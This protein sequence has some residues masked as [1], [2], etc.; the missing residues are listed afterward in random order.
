MLKR[1]RRYI[2]KSWLIF[3]RYQYFM[4]L[5]LMVNIVSIKKLMS[6]IC[7]VNILLVAI[8]VALIV[9]LN[10]GFNDYVSASENRYK[11]YLLA[12][13][14][15]Q[16]SD[17]LTR[18]GRTYAITGVADYEKMY[19]DILDIRNGKIAR[20]KGYHKIYWDLVQNYG[21]KPSPDGETISLN[22]LMKQAGFTPREFELLAE[23]QANSDALVNLEVKSMNAVKGKFKDASSGQYTIIGEPDFELARNLLHGK[24]YHQEK[25]KIME[26]I[27]QFLGVMESRTHLARDKALD[28]VSF[29]VTLANVMV[30]LILILAVVSF[31][32]IKVRVSDRIDRV[33]KTLTE[34][35]HNSDLTRELPSKSNDEVGNIS[36]NINTMI[37]NFRVAITNIHN[38]SDAVKTITD[39]IVE[40][41]RSSQQISDVQKTETT[42]AAAAVE[43]MSLALAEVAKNTSEVSS[44]TK[45]TDEDAGRGKTIVSNTISQIRR[46]SEEFES[47][48]IV[49]TELAD[50]TNNVGSVLVVI[51]SIA[52]Q[53]NLLALNAAIEAARA[54][55]Q[56][57]G[58]A[59][60]ADEVRSLAQRTQ[61]STTEIEVMIASLKSKASDAITSIQSGASRLV[62]TT[63]IVEE[64]DS[65]LINIV[66]SMKRLADLTTMIA[67]ATEE[68]A[69]VSGDIS[70]NIVNIDDNSDKVA[71]GFTTLSHSAEQLASASSKMNESIAI[72]KL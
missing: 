60:V 14:L 34:I 61:E 51:Q 72:F 38:M 17:D 44:N 69:A 70:R 33:S 19:F 1:G 66:E 15:R 10:Y 4:F 50:E 57:R 31:W 53:T 11:S 63:K 16:S 25:A 37:S 49:V 3:P 52:Q 8:T 23:A 2:H 43:E 28:T 46:L 21:D 42:M 64:A 40:V 45:K 30:I 47:T 22:E 55:E 7:G 67:T 56:G 58:F 29:M 20:P 27:Q 9:G 39:S 24:K 71:S 54:G 32:I 12:D 68:Q 62:D 6:L 59:V 18:L 48:S 13:E 41:V 5:L 36:R 65:S 26:P 35:G